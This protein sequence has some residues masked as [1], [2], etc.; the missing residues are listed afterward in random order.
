[1]NRKE[2]IALCRYLQ[3]LCPNQKLDKHTPDAW[4]DILA[5]IDYLDAKLAIRNITHQNNKYALNIDVRMI[6]NEAKTIRQNRRNKADPTPTENNRPPT[7]PA[8]YCKWLKQQN[9]QQ[10]QLEKQ[11]WANNHT[12]KY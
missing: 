7:D 11:Q 9:H 12:I 6:Y 10:A 4:A 2:T 8:A 5:N 1:M 3:A